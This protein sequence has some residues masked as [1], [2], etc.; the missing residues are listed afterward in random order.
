MRILLALLPLAFLALAGCSDSGF[1][2]S[3]EVDDNYFKPTSATIDAGDAIH[4]EVESD[5]QNAHTIT[6]H[7]A[8]DPT[9]T[10]L[11]DQH[12]SAGDDAHFT[13]ASAGT[14]HVWCQIH[15]GMTS[16][17]HTLITVE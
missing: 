17:M 11:L 2:G 13:F 12:V 15:G 7:K 9:T 1:S 16:G 6:I 8:G 5:A 10:L 14:Y 4:F 3:I